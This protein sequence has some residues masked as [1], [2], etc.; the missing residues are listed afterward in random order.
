[1]NHSP[2]EIMAKHLIDVGLGVADP[3]AEGAVFFGH[4]PD[5]PDACICVYD[6]AGT[7][8]GRIQQ[9]GEAIQHPGL[10]IQTRA[11]KYVDAGRLARR[12]EAHVDTIHRQ[13]ISPDGYH[14]YLLHAVSRTSPAFSAGQERDKTRRHLFSV[15][16][17]VTVEELPL[18]T[19]TTEAPA[20]TTTTP[21]T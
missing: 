14:Q 3:D 10:L 5:K 12:I 18:A 7:M 15:N 6:T 17:I 16:M 1:M 13:Q 21:E 20:T 4:R 2:A 9:T 19:T 8:D 11:L